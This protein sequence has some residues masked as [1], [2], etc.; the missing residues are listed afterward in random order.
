MKTTLG[1]INGKL[2]NYRRKK[3]SLGEDTTETIQ[4]ETHCKKKNQK[5]EHQY[6]VGQNVN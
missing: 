4:N 5:S 3:I 6:V 1:E 2:K